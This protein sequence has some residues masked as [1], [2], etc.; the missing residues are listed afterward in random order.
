MIDAVQTFRDHESLLTG[1][2]GFLGKVILG[3]LF[4]RFPDLRRLHVLVRPRGGSSSEERFRNDVL[5]S[6]PLAHR[7]APERITI[8]SGDIAEP[9]CGLD[10]ETLARLTGRVGLIV[11][12]AGLVE[13]SPP[14]DESF[15][16]NVD[17]VENVI[18]LAKRLGARLVH[19]STCFVCGEC[20]GL[21]EESE[22]IAGFY[23][24]RKGPEDA[25]FRHRHEIGYMRERIRETYAAAGNGQAVPGK[26]LAQRLV[27][28]G[29]QRA[30]QWGW[31]NIYTYA[32]SLGEQL[33]A[34]ESGLEW[35]IVRPAIV[36]AALEFPFP[37]WVEG[38]RT[39]APLVIMAMSGMR[40]WPVRPEAPLEVVPVDQVAAAI[41]TAGVLLLN[42]ESRRVYQVGTAE[43]NP[44]PLGRL[45]E[46]MRE[47]YR[48]SGRRGLRRL[49]PALGVRILSPPRARAR[50][51]LLQRRF[52]ALQRLVVGLRRIVQKAGL[53][54]R[55]ALSGLG[56]TL[57]ALGLQVQFREQTLE[58]YQPFMLDNRFIF[59][60]Q[61]IRRAHARLSEE[62]RRRLPWTPE[63]I[64]WRRYWL[65]HEVAGIMKWV[66]PEMARGRTVQT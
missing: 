27:D 13:F 7:K 11:N 9:A 21:V 19:V 38:G 16:S 55:R 61:N 28:L 18:A 49:L 46:W 52:A 57:R 50:R 32:K 62:D 40:H 15:R 10:E 36:E 20:D 64:D 63:R 39:A 25:S 41:L 66:Q 43:S 26:E 48:R 42:G 37:G 59:E 1:A 65:R 33:I 30:A 5:G 56:V 4:D 23:P 8:H 47:E 53:P 60:A 17:G 58:L 31:V 54:G 44:A 51:M 14:V 6:P 24:R 2:N 12:C 22:P 35:A 34:A 3:L 29:T 45:V